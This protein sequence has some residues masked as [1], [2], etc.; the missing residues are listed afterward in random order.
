MPVTSLLQLCSCNV[1]ASWSNLK[2]VVTD[3]KVLFKG[4]T[5]T[6]DESQYHD[7]YCSAEGTLSNLGSRIKTRVDFVWR[8]T[9]AYTLN[10]S[11][12]EAKVEATIVPFY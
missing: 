6:L 9:N 12:L 5:G 8:T 2:V 11:L 3:S 10:S 4:Y 7:G 1:N